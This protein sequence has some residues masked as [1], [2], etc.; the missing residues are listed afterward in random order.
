MMGILLA[1]AVDLHMVLELQ[2]KEEMVALVAVVT[3]QHTIQLLTLQKD[4]QVL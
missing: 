4:C 1:A 2:L 3:V